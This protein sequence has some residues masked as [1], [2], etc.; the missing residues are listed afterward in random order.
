MQTIDRYV[1]AVRL[2]NS[3]DAGS[4]TFSHTKTVIYYYLS[5]ELLCHTRPALPKMQALHLVPTVLHRSLVP[6][7][8]TTSSCV[9]HLIHLLVQTS[10]IRPRSELANVLWIMG[11]REATVTN[12]PL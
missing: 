12:P 3:F 5:N 4:D 6:S 8:L 9:L 1:F 7:Y 2:W 11:M 10:T